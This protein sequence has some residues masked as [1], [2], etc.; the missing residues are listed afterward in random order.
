MG[1]QI[2]QYVVCWKFYL[3]YEA[4][5]KVDFTTTD[6][7][8]DTWFGSTLFAQAWQSV[9]LLGIIIVCYTEVK[10]LKPVWNEFFM[11]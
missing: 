4:L 10:T 6:T 11:F 9:P 3:E 7:F 1:A 8:C 2:Y 5:K